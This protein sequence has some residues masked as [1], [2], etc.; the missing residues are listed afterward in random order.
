MELSHY[1]YDYGNNSSNFSDVGNVTFYYFDEEI[2]GLTFGLFE[3]Y[4]IPFDIFTLVLAISGWI[5]IEITCKGNIR[6]TYRIKT[7]LLVLRSSLRIL[8]SRLHFNVMGYLDSVDYTIFD[9]LFNSGFFEKTDSLL[10]LI[11]Q[12]IS[13]AF[14]N[15]LYK[16]TCAFEKGDG[17]NTMVKK[18]LLCVLFVV[19]FKVS[20]EVFFHSFMRKLNFWNAAAAAT[21]VV[22]TVQPL[23][24][25]ISCV[26]TFY[27]CYAGG[28][29]IYSIFGSNEFVSRACP[30]L[31]MRNIYLSSIAAAV[32]IS[33]VLMFVVILTERVMHS[34][35]GA[36][37]FPCMSKN[38]LA[39]QNGEP[40]Q[41]YVCMAN[42]FGNVEWL[43]YI[44][45]SWPT[46]IEMEVAVTVSLY[47]FIRKLYLHHYIG[48]R[49][50]YRRT[51]IRFSLFCYSA[52]HTN[53]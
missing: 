36:E 6:N 32:T 30:R 1:N 18:S 37:A 39:M 53:S 51:S 19:I 26:S 42:Y 4:I 41:S 13:V 33:Q 50:I 3:R 52:F 49:A 46:L 20:E 28:Y 12:M 29:V 23:E 16:C 8:A 31:K 14:L 2:T 38:V 43:D 15:I 11:I 40:D 44:D 48:R 22:P 5:I 24:I 17:K 27:C 47:K 45:P 25:I 35:H 10:L 9:F 7:I 21:T 34:I